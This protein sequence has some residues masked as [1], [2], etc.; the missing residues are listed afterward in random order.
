MVQFRISNDNQMTLT[1]DG[2]FGVNKENPNHK[3]DVNGLTR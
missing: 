1:V 3:L 2:N